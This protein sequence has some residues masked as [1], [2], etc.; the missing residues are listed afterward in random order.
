[1]LSYSAW[2]YQQASK[3]ALFLPKKNICPDEAFQER[4]KNSGLIM[5]HHELHQIELKGITTGKLKKVQF[6]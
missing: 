5:K 6:C 2:I 4:M 3:K 1:M